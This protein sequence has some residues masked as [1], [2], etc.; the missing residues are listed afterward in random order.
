MFVGHLALGL[1]GKRAAPSVSLGWFVAAVTA[2][3][4]L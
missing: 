4:L 2:C 3:D 1:M